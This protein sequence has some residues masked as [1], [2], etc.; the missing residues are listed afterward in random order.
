MSSFANI[1]VRYLILNLNFK[2]FRT[3][4]LKKFVLQ[5]GTEPNMLV[6]K[7]NQISIQNFTCGG[8]FER[9]LKNKQ[10]LSDN[11][12]NLSPLALTNYFPGQ[13]HHLLRPLP[14]RHFIRPTD[15]WLRFKVCVKTYLPLASIMESAHTRTSFSVRDRAYCSTPIC[16]VPGMRTHLPLTRRTG[17]G[18]RTEI[19]NGKSNFNWKQNIQRF[20]LRPAFGMSV[21]PVQVSIVLSSGMTRMTMPTV[22][23]RS[24]STTR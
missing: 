7:K 2:Q 5:S 10:T 22:S 15:N 21:C 23:R 8:M 6:V 17:F 1:P 14:I 19:G 4:V 3:I 9:L 13:N 16:F 12:E 11:N 20:L 24:P 18:I